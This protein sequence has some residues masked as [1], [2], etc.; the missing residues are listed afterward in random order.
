MNY[1]DNFPG[2][3]IQL[4][5]VKQN[6]YEIILKLESKNPDKYFYYLNIGR[7]FFRTTNSDNV[8]RETV[9]E[10]AYEVVRI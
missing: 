8:A 2:Q 9:D 7:I 4:L 10:N 6:H 5:H 1:V 3:F